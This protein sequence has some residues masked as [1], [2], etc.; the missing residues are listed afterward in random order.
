LWGDR[1]QDRAL[2]HPAGNTLGS[3]QFPARKD[4]LRIRL[5]EISCTE[6]KNIIAAGREREKYR[7]FNEAGKGQKR[8]D[9]RSCFLVLTKGLALKVLTKKVRRRHQ[10]KGG[11]AVSSYLRNF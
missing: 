11:R 4:R 8:R 9:E 2:S 5:E 7:E 1:L 10:G 3:R 6:E